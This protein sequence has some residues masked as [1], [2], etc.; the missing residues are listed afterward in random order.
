MRRS[1][2]HLYV[3][4]IN[5]AQP[6]CLDGR[7]S[8]VTWQWHA[9][10]GHLGFQGSGNYRRMAWCANYHWSTTSVPYSHKYCAPHLLDLVH[11]DLCSYPGD[12]WMEVVPPCR[13]QESLYV[14]HVAG[15]KG[16]GYGSHHPTPGTRRDEAK[17][18][19]VASPRRTCWTTIAPSMT[20]TI[21]LCHTRPS[22]MVGVQRHNQR[23]LAWL[24]A[25]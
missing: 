4:D 22:I 2:S 25:C 15:V 9:R 13:W 21:S 5:I 24:E 3:L 12:T 23:C 8:E 14:A 17:P 20:S 19:M 10:F 18:T 7:R 1:A 16:P 11:A 6:L